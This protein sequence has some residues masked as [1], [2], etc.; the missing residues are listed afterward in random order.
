MKSVLIFW[1]ALV[2]TAVHSCTLFPSNSNSSVLNVQEGLRAQVEV[3]LEN[4]DGRKN[5]F[6][7]VIIRSQPERTIL[8]TCAHCQPRTDEYII[9]VKYNGKLYA[10]PDAKFIHVASDGNLMTPGLDLALI[11]FTRLPVVRPV[12]LARVM[13]VL[14]ATIFSVGNKFGQGLSPSMGL[15]AGTLQGDKLH[16]V[17]KVVMPLHP[18]NSGGIILYDCELVGIVSYVVSYR[19]RI[20]GTPLA[21]PVRVETMGF[22]VPVTKIRQYLSLDEVQALINLE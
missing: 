22:I 14:G 16:G 6:T 12:R 7:A 20:P 9:K 10:D 8:L 18:G 1:V 4:A 2:A 5:S 11:K 17:H 15:Y 19:T 13:P 3:L 21:V